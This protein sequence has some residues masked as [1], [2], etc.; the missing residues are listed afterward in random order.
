MQTLLAR[1]MVERR[2]FGRV[3]DIDLGS[4]QVDEEACWCTM[5]EV[6]GLAEPPFVKLTGED[7]SIRNEKGKG[8]AEAGTSHNKKHQ[9]T[10]S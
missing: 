6:R 2:S 4:W 5:E 9:S 1:L 3:V 8:P 10:S 7:K